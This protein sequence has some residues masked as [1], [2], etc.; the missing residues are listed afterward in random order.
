MYI[1]EPK[2]TRFGSKHIYFHSTG[3]SSDSLT[4]VWRLVK[5]LNGDLFII[6]PDEISIEI[7][8]FSLK[9]T[10]LKTSSVV[11]G[12]LILAAMCWIVL[13]KRT[14]SHWKK[15][16]LILSGWT[17][18]TILCLVSGMMPYISDQI[19]LCQKRSRPVLSFISVA[20]VLNLTICVLTLWWCQLS[21]YW[22]V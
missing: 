6:F 22:N 1:W 21:G 12:Y 13:P 9:K 3:S 19:L 4:P 18:Y 5:P 11:W 16:I 8:T 17:C 14:D 2:S 10:H 15:I 20:I 7:Q